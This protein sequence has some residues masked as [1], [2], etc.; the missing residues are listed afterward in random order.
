MK[1]NGIERIRGMI[2]F[3]RR[4]GKAVI[5]TE[6]VCRAM[7]KGKVKLVVISNAASDATKKKLTVKSDF[8]GIKSIEA[9]IDTESLGKILGK[10]GAVAAVA[11]EDDRFAEEI[12]KAAVSE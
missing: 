3:A 12:I 4:A 10:S 9:E 1:S 5:G 11:I 6:L 8:Y 2:G 7:P